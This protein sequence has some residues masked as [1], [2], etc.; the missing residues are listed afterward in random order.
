M[1]TGD[2]TNYAVSTVIMSKSVK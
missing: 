1:H 2:I